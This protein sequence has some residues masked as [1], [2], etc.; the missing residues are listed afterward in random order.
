MSTLLMLSLL[1]APTG[2]TVSGGE[3]L[4]VAGATPA[5]GE[6]G[7]NHSKPGDNKKKKKQQTQRRSGNFGSDTRKGSDPSQD[8]SRRSS[9]RPTSTVRAQQNTSDSAGTDETVTSSPSGAASQQNRKPN[10]E[11]AAGNSGLVGFDEEQDT[12]DLR[13]QVTGNPIIRRKVAVRLPDPE[14][15]DQLLPPRYYDGLEEIAPGQY[16]GL[17]HKVGA[18]RLTPQQAVFDGLVNSGM[19]ARGR[20]DGRPIEITRTI[21]VRP[22]AQSAGP[23]VRWDVPLELPARQAP[24][25]VPLQLGPPEVPITQA[26]V[27]LPPISPAPQLPVIPPEVVVTPIPRSPLAPPIGVSVPDIADNLP[28]LPIGTAVPPVGVPATVVPG[29]PTPPAG[30]V[31]IPWGAPNPFASLQTEYDSLYVEYVAILDRRTALSAAAGFAQRPADVAEWGALD[32]LASQVAQRQLQIGV[33]LHPPA[34]AAVPA[35]PPPVAA[36]PGGTGVLGTIGRGLA[37]VTAI[38]GAASVFVG[39]FAMPVPV[40]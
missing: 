19:P 22:P 35:P 1:L 20:L 2:F 30:P 15:P 12:F 3:R 18:G 29:F 13:E 5:P 31:G 17:E 38:A 16:R 9:Q 10:G 14:N 4:A 6:P 28:P 11:W 26:P 34:P 36:P 39:P 8:S 33:L 40:P 27:E 37:G 24:P 25:E 32:A 21:I 7:G 23:E